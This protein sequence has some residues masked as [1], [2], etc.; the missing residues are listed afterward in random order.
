MKTI[1]FWLGII[2]LIVGSFFIGTL[3]GQKNIVAQY[4]GVDLG[5]LWEAWNTLEEKYVPSSSD[6]KSESEVTDEDKVYAAIRGLASAYDDPYTSFF[7]PSENELFESDIQG[8]FSGIGI[9][10]GVVNDVLTV[11]SPLKRTPAERAGLRAQDIIAEI[12]GVDSLTINPSEA[13][14]RIRGERGTIVTL[15]IARAGEGELIQIPITRDLIEI[16]TIETSV[17]DGVFIIEFYTFNARATEEFIAALLEFQESGVRDLIID[18]RGNP[19]GFLSSAVDI[20]S[21]F[22]EKD[23]IVVTEDYGGNAPNNIR[24]SK[25]LATIGGA[26]QIAILTDAGSASASEILAGALR[27]YD[28]A[29]LIGTNT[30]GKGS[31]QEL[32]T[33]TDETS[34]KI[35]IARWILPSGE[36]ISN[37]GIDPD[38]EVEDDPETETDEVLERALQFLQSGE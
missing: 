29:T 1:P 8:E 16:P 19:G 25:G 26:T 15:G 10:I 37:D 24:R 35:T 12:N 31:V 30:F 21:L 32:V 23:Q 3:Y 17:R 18:L 33:I 27:D 13:A 4:D 14:Q 22:I 7:P 20:A 38:I 36:Q 5:P 6:A 34:L 28:L 11:I 9:E 2:I